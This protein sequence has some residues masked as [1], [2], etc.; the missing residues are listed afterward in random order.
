[1]LNSRDNRPSEA[2]LRQAA[3]EARQY[4]I[5]IANDALALAQR[6]GLNMEAVEAKLTADTDMTFERIEKALDYALTHDW[7]MS[8]D[9]SMVVSGTPPRRGADAP[10]YHVKGRGCTCPAHFYHPEKGFCHHIWMR[11]ITLKAMWTDYLNSQQAIRDRLSVFSAV[12]L[13]AEADTVTI[14]G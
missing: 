6:T 5:R 13:M 7:R 14:G 12:G 9:G 10:E 3:E 1:M 8:A 4:R 2:A 11:W